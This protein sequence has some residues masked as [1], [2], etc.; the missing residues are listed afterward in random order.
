MH[1]PQGSFTDNLQCFI[2]KGV[3]HANCPTIGEEEKVGT[4]SVVNQFNRPSTKKN[5]KFFCDCFL[6]KFEVELASDDTR[7]LNNF[8]GNITTIMSELHE[9]KKIL[10]ENNT[11]KEVETSQ[12]SNAKANNIWFD[13]ERLESTKTAP[14]GPILVLNDSQEVNDSVEKAIIENSIP[15]T[16]SFKNKSGD[17]IVVCDTTDSRDQLQRIIQ[18]NTE[19]VTMKPVTKKKPSVTIVGL[20]KKYSKDEVLKLLVT[21]NQHIKQFSTV[22]DLNEHIEIHDVKPTR[23]KQSVFQVFASVSEVLRSGLKNFDDKVTIGLLKCKV[24]D[25]YHVKRC[26]NCQVLGHY[27]KDCP[28]PQETNCAKCSQK[29]STDTCTVSE[30]KCINCFKLNKP[31][32]HTAFDHKCPCMVELIE[33]KKSL[34]SQRKTMEHK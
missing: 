16:K 2:C 29:H 33:K 27:Y 11:T 6:T 22:N 32:D 7:R 8:E 30:N 12:N 9:K 10:K 1:I 26:N 18:T 21:Q 20:S 3:F 23:A 34:N 4:K 14:S 15:V 28:T 5:F 13:K 31:S 24:Y 17:L 25:R 19:N